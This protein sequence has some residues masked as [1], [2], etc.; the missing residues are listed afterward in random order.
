MAIKINSTKNSKTDN[1][2]NTQSLSIHVSIIVWTRI[3][4]SIASVDF[5]R[6]EA[7][8]S[9]SISSKSSSERQL[10]LLATASL[11]A[12]AVIFAA[13]GTSAGLSRIFKIVVT[14]GRLWSPI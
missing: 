14:L 7:L 13:H 12:L 11:N 8:A 10:R 5:F 3:P 6:Y 9:L 1:G 2:V 4:M